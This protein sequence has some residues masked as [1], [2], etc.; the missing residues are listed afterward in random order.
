M[1]NIF[2]GPSNPHQ[3]RRAVRLAP[4]VLQLPRQVRDSCD[5]VCEMI[6]R[7]LFDGLTVR[8]KLG[9]LLIDVLGLLSVVGFMNPARPA[10]S[11]EDP[12]NLSTVPRRPITSAGTIPQNYEL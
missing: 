1:E 12:R 10:I 7:R 2:P 11:R 9:T 4:T 8:W 3:R 5:D 6:N